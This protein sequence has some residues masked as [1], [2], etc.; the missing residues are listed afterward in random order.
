MN[1]EV[2]RRSNW[3]TT[4]TKLKILL[5][6]LPDILEILTLSSC[7]AS[8]AQLAPNNNTNKSPTLM[9]MVPE[10]TTFN[11]NCYNE[12][13]KIIVSESFTNTIYYNCQEGFYNL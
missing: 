13:L 11:K 12:I 5:K 2:K 7:L 1:Y 8:E 3:S 4:R 10:I 9:F 6:Y